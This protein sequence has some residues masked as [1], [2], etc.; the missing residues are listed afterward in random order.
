VQGADRL[1][2]PVTGLGRAL[3]TAG[4]HGIGG[5]V[6]I[7]RVGLALGAA[8][9]PVRPVDLDHLHTLAGQVAGER[10]TVGAG[11][12]HSDRVQ[13]PEPA[14]PLQ[15]RPVPGRGGRELRIGQPAAVHQDHRRVMGVL[16]RVDAPGDPSPSRL[17]GHTGHH[18][19][20]EE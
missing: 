12:L 14:H 15:Q 16:V 4:Q 1:G 19:F 2:D 3:G 5:G 9:P 11:P 10:G 8:L 20:V 17:L 6:G 7:E 13:P 18:A